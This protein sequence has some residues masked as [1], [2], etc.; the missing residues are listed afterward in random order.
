MW[1][2]DFFFVLQTQYLCLPLP[3]RRRVK[4]SCW[5][6][7]KASNSLYFSPILLTSD[8]YINFKHCLHNYMQACCNH[9][10][11]L[12]VAMVTPNQFVLLPLCDF[13]FSSLSIWSLWQHPVSFGCKMCPQW[14]LQHIMCLQAANWLSTGVPARVWQWWKNLSKWMPPPSY[15]VYQSDSNKYSALR[16]LSRWVYQTS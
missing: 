5:P 14:K 13:F 2:H 10:N 15:C 9:S 8:P 6:G 4:Q 3:C 16:K 11:S 1:L 12:V 7:V